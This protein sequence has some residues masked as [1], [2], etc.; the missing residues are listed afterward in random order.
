MHKSMPHAGLARFREEINSIDT[1]L[2]QLFA[3]RM[4]LAEQVAAHKKKSGDKVYAPRREQ[5]MLAALPAALPGWEK[6]SP[7]LMRTLLRLSRRR[8]YEYLLQEKTEKREALSK[9]TAGRPSP[10]S[11]CLTVEL[12]ADNIDGADV[13]NI[14]ADLNIMPRSMRR[15]TINN[16]ERIHLEIEAECDKSL[17]LALYQLKEETGPGG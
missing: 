15:Q 2:L 9:K 7:I 10:T 6:Y 4:R 11:L 8:Q 13:F 5:E 14:F 1:Q 17:A 3:Q 12:G 16:K